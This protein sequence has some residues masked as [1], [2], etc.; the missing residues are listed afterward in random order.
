VRYASARR[1]LFSRTA[2]AA[3]PV[4]VGERAF[5]GVTCP[6]CILL[7]D[8]AEQADWGEAP[9]LRAGSELRPEGVRTLDDAGNLARRIVEKMKSFPLLPAEAFG[10][11]GVHTGN[12]AELLVRKSPGDGLAPMRVGRDIRRY[13]ARSPSLW[14]VK[15]PV[16]EEGRYFR[17]GLEKKYTEARILIRQTAAYP[18]AA[19]HTE[20]GYFRNSLLACY[21]VDGLSDEYLLAILN[22]RLVRF[23]HQH[24]F[25]DG[26]QKAF[27]QVKVSH[28][29]AI[30][31]PRPHGR[32]AREIEGLV[33]RAEE[34]GPDL[35]DGE[36]DRLVY[37]LY[38]LDEEEIAEVERSWG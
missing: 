6:A 22:S 8:R 19:R 34:A 1:A 31:A 29:R 23:F 32:T 36:I 26:R 12:S 5:R 3:E 13:S 7:L 24:E 14:L 15:E 25:R 27:P 37:R 16:V 20:P 18:I 17:I 4:K 33:R 21:G 28:L 2:L 30:P 35:V 38:G 10:D 9:E 11:P